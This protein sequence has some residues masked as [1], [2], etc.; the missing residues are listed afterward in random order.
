MKT[1]EEK[2][3]FAQGMGTMLMSSVGIDLFREEGWIA[4]I[5][6]SLMMASCILVYMYISPEKDECKK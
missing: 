2:K 6:Y 4:L 3:G 5:G 1:K